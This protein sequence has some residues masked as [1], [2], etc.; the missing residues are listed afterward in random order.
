MTMMVAGAVLIHTAIAGLGAFWQRPVVAAQNDGE[1]GIEIVDNPPE[2]GAENIQYVT[3]ANTAP[4]LTPENPMSAPENVAVN[5]PAPPMFAPDISEPSDVA[6]TVKPRY[7]AHPPVGTAGPAHTAANLPGGPSGN[8]GTA[9]G[10]QGWKTPKPPYP[11][12]L[13]SAGFQGATTVRITTDASGDIATVEIVKSA[14]NALLNRNTQTYVR[15]FWKGPPN[16]TRTTE[17]VYQLR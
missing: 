3:V 8:R 17:F 15:Q 14:G 9:A 2:S 6:P 12:A 5:E 1:T 10:G 11:V 4:A 13:Q 7:S 16:A